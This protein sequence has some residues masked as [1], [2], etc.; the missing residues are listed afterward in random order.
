M[1]EGNFWICEKLSGEEI[2]KTNTGKS[3][4]SLLI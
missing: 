2:I 4:E 3:Q 1:K